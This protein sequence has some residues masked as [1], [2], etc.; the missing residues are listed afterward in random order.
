[1]GVNRSWPNQLQHISHSEVRAHMRQ[2]ERQR[3]QREAKTP[4]D[5]ARLAHRHSLRGHRSLPWIRDLATSLC[6]GDRV[7]PLPDVLANR[8]IN[9]RGPARGSLPMPRLTAALS[10][11]KRLALSPKRSSLP[12]TLPRSCTSCDDTRA[13][14]SRTVDA[15]ADDP[16]R[17][18]GRQGDRAARRASSRSSARSRSRRSAGGRYGPATRPANSDRC[19]Q[20]DADRGR[21][22]F[23]LRRCVGQRRRSSPRATRRCDEP[24]DLPDARR[25][26]SGG[27]VGTPVRVEA[28]DPRRDHGA[29][30]AGIEKDVFFLMRK[31]NPRYSGNKN[32]GLNAA[33]CLCGRPGDRLTARLN[34]RRILRDSG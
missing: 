13:S 2:C 4:R 9:H 21:A 27:R 5:L 24:D 3:G 30:R 11:R 34:L 12:A 28:D 19:D 17:A 6:W 22:S 25:Q 32:Q 31:L 1:M 26:R 14:A 20:G 18:K 33:G 7:K 15:R 16:D 23:Q 10:K 8:K 29:W